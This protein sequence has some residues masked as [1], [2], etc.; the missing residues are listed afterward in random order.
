MPIFFI[1]E[2]YLLIPTLNIRNKIE[3]SKVR[4]AALSHKRQVYLTDFRY[5]TLLF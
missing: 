2:T 1:G 4:L 3:N 5:T